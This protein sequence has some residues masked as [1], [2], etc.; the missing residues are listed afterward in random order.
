MLDPVVY[1]LAVSASL[2]ASVI[3]ALVANRFLARSGSSHSR[4][5]SLIGIG[6]SIFLGYLLLQFQ[7]AW[8]PA[9]ALDRFLIL[10]LPATFIVEIAAGVP[11]VYPELIRFLRI[12]L[13][14]T[15]ARILLHGSIYV[16]SDGSEWSANQL[17][18]IVIASAVLLAAVWMPMLSLLQRSGDVSITISLAMTTLAAGLVVMLAGYL[19]GGAASLPVASALLGAAVTCRRRADIQGMIG[20]GVMSLFSLLFIGRF[21]GGVTTTTAVVVFLSPL[22]CWIAELPGLRPHKPRQV[23]CTSSGARG[24]PPTDRVGQCET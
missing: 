23:F 13:M 8:P 15:T 5:V 16:R 21:F 3:W 18:I 19:K 11:R 2:A 9:Q 4:I 7:F 10:I 24:H 12:V 22:L 14:A 17:A 6:L 20:I 1:F